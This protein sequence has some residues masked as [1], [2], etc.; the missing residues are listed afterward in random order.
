[1]KSVHELLSLFMIKLSNQTRSKNYRKISV[2][3]TMSLILLSLISLADLVHAQTIFQEPVL[4]G[5]RDIPNTHYGPDSSKILCNN[6]IEVRGV[7][8]SS[9][10]EDEDNIKPAGSAIDNDATTEW[11][12]DKV[13]E[14]I[15]LDLG[16]TRSICEIKILWNDGDE[17]SY[18]FIVSV[19]ENGTVFKD[20]MRAVSSGNSSFPESY[21]FPDT[22]A[23]LV[24]LTMYGNSEDESASMKELSLNGRDIRK[25]GDQY[26]V[27]GPQAILD[28]SA[29]PSQSG[30]PPYNAVDGDSTTAWSSLGVGS[31]IQSDLGSLKTICGVNIAWYDGEA[32]QYK[33]EI[34]V[35]KDGINFN[36][37]YEGTSSGNSIRPDLY[38]LPDVNA[39]YVKITVFGNDK[40]DWAGITGL[41]IQGFVPP[42]PPNRPPTADSKHVSTD[43]NAPVNIKLS[44]I[45]PEGS[46]PTF[47]VVD[48]PKH[49][50]LSSVLRDVVKYAPDKDFAGSDSFT[51]TV[52]DNRGMASSKATVTTSV[53]EVL[54]CRLLS[55]T[56]I[57]AI[58]S[59]ANIPSNVIDDNLNTRWSKNGIG[60]WIQFDLGSRTKICSVDIAWYRG[61]MR[62][63]DF[64]V[65]ISNDSSTFRNVFAGKGSGTTTGFEKYNLPTG[66]E[67]RYVRITVD[68]NTENNWASIAE[69]A[70]FGSSNDMVPQSPLQSAP[71]SAAQSP[72]PSAPQSPSNPSEGGDSNQPDKWYQKGLQ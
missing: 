51:Y 11:S 6:P 69:I 36:Q 16:T 60:S 65:S 67:A 45:D 59:D 9:S 46:L 44:G 8:S 1:M 20:V 70:M 57:T 40:N 38:T 49:G 62:Q 33:F 7:S 47:T 4:N 56:M 12:T 52:K 41:S 42:P 66:S 34:S 32:K 54:Q 24:R 3:F 19:S 18:N 22:K 31:F 10:S 35:S 25:V 14:Y 68:R 23:K 26:I 55:P 72:P 63:N 29:G 17:R 30:D 53:K 15:Q 48:L 5:S 58:G 61:D 43:M 39:R 21:Q 2:T 64:A 27:C 37:V 28:L 13:G 50:Q 71:H